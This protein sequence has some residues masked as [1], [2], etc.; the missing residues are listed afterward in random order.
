METTALV[1]MQFS[2]SFLT[3][4]EIQLWWSQQALWWFI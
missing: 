2:K 3:K 1:Q 4:L